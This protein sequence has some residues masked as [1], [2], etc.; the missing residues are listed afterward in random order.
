MSDLPEADDIRRQMQ[1]TRLRVRDE[2]DGV[3]TGAK[4]LADWRYYPARFPW[5]TLGAAA[6]IGFLIIPRRLQTGPDPKELEEMI[7]RHSPAQEAS[8]K[9]AR[10]GSL[11][12][13]LVGTASGAL[14]KMGITYAGRELERRLQPQRGGRTP[15]PQ[16]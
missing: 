1:L 15:E 9:G 4:E 13:T 5:A 2:V 8:K 3:V 16:P 6:A 10:K 14:L 12:G 7:R 11:L